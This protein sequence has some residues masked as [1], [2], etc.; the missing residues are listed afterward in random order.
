MASLVNSEGRLSNTAE[1]S[2]QLIDLSDDGHSC[3]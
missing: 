1:S 2:L 3:L